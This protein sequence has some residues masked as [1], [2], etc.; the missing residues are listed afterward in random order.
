MLMTRDAK[1]HVQLLRLVCPAVVLGHWLDFVL[2]VSPGVLK[3]AG[4]S[5][6]FLEIGCLLVFLCI[7]L[8]VVLKG[9]TRIGLVA[10]NDPM[11]EKSIHHHA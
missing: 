8:F 3:S 4:G 1:R 11:L 10:K 6:G 2:M 7:F 5:V 9:L